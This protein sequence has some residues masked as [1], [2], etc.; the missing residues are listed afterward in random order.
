LQQFP[1]AHGIGSKIV[2]TFRSGKCRT[3]RLG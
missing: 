2:D 3:K 1:D